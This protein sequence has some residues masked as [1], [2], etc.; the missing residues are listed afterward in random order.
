MI[1]IWDDHDF[2]KNDGGKELKDKDKNRNLWL[3][4]IDEPA[5]SER[6]LQTGTTI[7][8]DFFLTK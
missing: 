4:F 8:Q 7:H 1:G 5:D 3:D 2:G 6:R